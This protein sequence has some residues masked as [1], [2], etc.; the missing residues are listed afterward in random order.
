[1]C[2]QSRTEFL[3][4]FSV[5]LFV[6]FRMSGTLYK[7]KGQFPVWRVA[8]NYI[9]LNKSIPLLRGMIAFQMQIVPR[10]GQNH[11]KFGK[12][13]TQKHIKN[14]HC[15]NCKLAQFCHQNGTPV[16][17]RKRPQNHNNSQNPQNPENGQKGPPGASQITKNHESDFKN[18]RKSIANGSLV[19]L[20]FSALLDNMS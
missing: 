6:L 11:K 2:T 20:L 5:L 12:T 3:S 17:W 10:G 15:D 1:M 16:S 18:S 19:A 4:I 8:G 13:S 7:L 14:K 9:K